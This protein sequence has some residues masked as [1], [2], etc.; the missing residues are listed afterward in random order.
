MEM[1]ERSMGMKQ[2]VASSDIQASCP[3]LDCAINCYIPLVNVGTATPVYDDARVSRYHNPGVGAFS[4]YLNGT[5]I[6]TRAI[7]AGGE[8]FKFY[9]NDWYVI[10]IYE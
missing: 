5:T 9:G 4:P 2:E 1:A 10:H 3:G 6:V 8:L 7:P